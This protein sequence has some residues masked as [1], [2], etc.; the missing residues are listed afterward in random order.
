MPSK[1]LLPLIF[2]RK[3]V[4]VVSISTENCLKCLS[5]HL[6]KRWFETIGQRVSNEGFRRYAS[7]RRSKDATDSAVAARRDE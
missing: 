1:T 4:S 5:V 2:I 3:D 7:W 6:M